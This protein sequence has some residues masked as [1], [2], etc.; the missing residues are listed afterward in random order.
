[1]CHVMDIKESEKKVVIRTKTG[2][3]SS[4]WFSDTDPV[5][6]LNIT[7]RTVKED[8]EIRRLCEKNSLNSEDVV[9]WFILRK[10]EEETV[11]IS[12]HAMKRIRERVGLNKSAALR[13][14]KKVYDN[15]KNAD[16]VKGYLSGWL[17]NSQIKSERGDKYLIYGEHLYVFDGNMLVTVINIPKKERAK[18]YYRYA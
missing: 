9:S 12:E 8:E 3:C 14:V 13:M 7:D 17:R 16:D 5:K 15:G 10:K 4:E 1:M 11:Y 18:E 6:C 2:N